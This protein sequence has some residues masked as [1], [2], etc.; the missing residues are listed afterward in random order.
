MILRQI[1]DGD[2]KKMNTEKS[3]ELAE[4]AL[5]LDLKDG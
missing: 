1:G 3:V 4:E 2:T 5:K